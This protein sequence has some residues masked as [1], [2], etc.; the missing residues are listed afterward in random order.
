MT[1]LTG[2]TQELLTRLFWDDLLS[3]LEVLYYLYPNLAY[4]CNWSIWL[5]FELE[6]LQIG[7]FHVIFLVK[8]TLVSPIS[9][10]S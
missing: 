2:S 10:M 6:I 8:N 1:S 4:P 9:D 3:I 5:V 7:D